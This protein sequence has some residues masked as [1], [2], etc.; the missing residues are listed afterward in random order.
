MANKSLK[1]ALAVT[2]AGALFLAGVGVLVE[3]GE[4][5]RHNILMYPVLGDQQYEACDILG[6]TGIDGESCD[7]ERFASLDELNEF[8]A[9]MENASYWGYYKDR[10]DSGSAA[11]AMG[12]SNGVQYESSTAR[13]S[14]TNI[15]V[16]GVDEGDILKNDGRYAYIISQDRGL[17]LIVD[18]RDPGRMS[19]L[20]EIRSEGQFM[21]LYLRGDKLLTIEQAYY[22]EEGYYGS[23]YRQCNWP[24]IFIKVFDVWDRENPRMLRADALMGEFAT[25]RII[26]DYIYVIGTQWPSQY[27]N[28]SELPVPLEALYYLE[29]ETTY[30]LTSF[31]SLDFMDNSSVP[32]VMGIFMDMSNVI[33]VSMENIYITQCSSGYNYYYDSSNETTAVHRISVKDGQMKY[34]AK[35]EVPGH[36]LN[37]FSMDECREHFRVATTKGQVWSTGE[38]AAVN[39]VYVLNMGMEMVGA[40]EGIAPGEKIYSARFMGDRC[41]LVTYKKVDPFFVIDLANPAHPAVLGYLKIPGYSDYLHPYDENHVIGLGKDTMESGSP[42]FEWYQGVKLAL[43]NVSDVANPTEIAHVVI[44]DRGSDSPALT[45]PHAFMFSREKNLLVLPVYLYEQN[46]LDNGYRAY[47]FRISPQEG[48]VEQGQIEHESHT[49]NQQTSY[50][51]QGYYSGNQITRSFY[52]DETLYTLSDQMLKANGLESL[53]ELGHIWLV[54]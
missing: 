27:S 24:T 6:G 39:M 38:D 40:L 45:D 51:W 42:N 28:E 7:L 12:A 8:L 36:V 2:A 37:R 26:G 17:V 14:T 4:N 21:E 32:T 49:E 43:F 34:R 5:S 30:C 46:G 33:Y 41:Y 25:S 19:I 18:V 48:I 29:N 9:G 20:S 52:I 50:Y 3:T 44:G 23:E 31:M 11:V 53:E 1:M 22:F 15:Q 54:E 47:V 10:P 16:S 13:Y 35:G